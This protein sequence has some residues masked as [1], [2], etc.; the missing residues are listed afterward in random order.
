M[1]LF[2]EAECP[3]GCRNGGFCNERHLCEC[4][5]GFYGPHCEKGKEQREP[6][7]LACFLIN[8]AAPVFLIHP[9]KLFF[10]LHYKNWRN[11]IKPQKSHW[12]VFLLGVFFCWIQYVVTGAENF[13]TMYT[14]FVT[15]PP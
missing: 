4:P 11:L 8:G 15:T 5:D 14:Y 13:G 12:K 1:F 10:W 6:D 7:A 2:G 9:L 3:G